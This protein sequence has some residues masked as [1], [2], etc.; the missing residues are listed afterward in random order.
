[1]DFYR[2]VKAVNSNIKVCATVPEESFIRIMGAQHAYDCIQ[3]RPYPVAAPA[4]APTGSSDE[5]FAR[6]AANTLKLGAEIQRT[7]QLVKK[8]AG[9]NAGRVDLVVSDYGRLT[10]YPADAPYFGGGAGEAVLN[11][12]CLREWVLAGV[13][14]AIRTSLV[15]HSSDPIPASAVPLRSPAPA[16]DPALFA[17][18]GPDTIVTPLALSIKL[19]R[20]HTGETRLASSIEGSPKVSASPAESMDALQT[21]ATRDALGNAYL[22]VINVD[23][24]HDIAA[25]VRSDG[26]TFGPVAEVTILASRDLNDENS[27]RNPQTISLKKADAAIDA[28]SIEL[29]FPKHSV[30]GI[31][32]IATK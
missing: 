9:G 28:A 31:K 26:G 1:V 27:P 10:A 20:M 15:D 6:M 29:S 7:Q 32:L 17:G 22:V 14:A 13:A 24:E 30:T 16:E 4:P 3:Q 23:P 8:Y 19:L 2:A 21:Y 5:G 12:L 18:P 25:T 11:A